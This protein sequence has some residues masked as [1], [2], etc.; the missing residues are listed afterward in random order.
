MYDIWNTN[1]NFI[2]LN[3]SFPAIQRR[4]F[5]WLHSV[6]TGI[7]AS[8]GRSYYWRK[9]SC[10]RTFGGCA[11]LLI[12][13]LALSDSFIS[14]TVYTCYVCRLHLCLAE[15]HHWKRLNWLY[16]RWFPSIW[17]NGVVCPHLPVLQ[18]LIALSFI[19]QGAKHEWNHTNKC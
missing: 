1:F 13:P 18:S 3:W 9:T 8:C 16:Q 7:F 2:H 5:P 19:S 15:R 6:S 14:I 4:Q 12:R 17:R 11:L 10:Q